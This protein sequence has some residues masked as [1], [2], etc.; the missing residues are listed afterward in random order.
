MLIDKH[1][2]DGVEAVAM[3]AMNTDAGKKLSEG[4]FSQDMPEH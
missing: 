4:K 2:I 1:G 3:R